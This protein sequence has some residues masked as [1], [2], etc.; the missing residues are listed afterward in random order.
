MNKKLYITPM[1]DTWRFP[2][3]MEGEGTPMV[4]AGSPAGG[5]G[6]SPIFGI[7]ARRLY[8]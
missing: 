8:V 3:I 1:C 2:D 6:E 4:D 5:N 7:P